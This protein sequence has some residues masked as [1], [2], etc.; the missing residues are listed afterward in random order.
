[1]SCITVNILISYESIEQKY[2]INR[3]IGK[4]RRLL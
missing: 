2:Y 4:V 3:M 1:M